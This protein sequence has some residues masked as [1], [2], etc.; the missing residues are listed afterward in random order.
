MANIVQKLEKSGLAEEFRAQDPKRALQWL[1]ENAHDDIY[2]DVRDYLEQ[3]GYR[4][5]MEV[6]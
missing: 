1:K 3:H 6:T 5:V 2:T 4:A